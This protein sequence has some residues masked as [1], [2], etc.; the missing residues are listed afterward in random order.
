MVHVYTLQ[1]ESRGHVYGTNTL[2]DCSTLLSYRQEMAIPQS[3]LGA[4][5]SQVPPGFG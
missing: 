4:S 1:A 5:F 2:T 3:V